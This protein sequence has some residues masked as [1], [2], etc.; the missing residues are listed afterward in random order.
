[1]LWSSDTEWA[2]YLGSGTKGSVIYAFEPVY[3]SIWSKVEVS[4]IKV[5]YKLRKETQYV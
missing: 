2:K 1:M 4:L 3:D 5:P